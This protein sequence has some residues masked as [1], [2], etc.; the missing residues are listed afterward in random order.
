MADTDALWESLW[1]AH[2]DGQKNCLML[3]QYV[4][5]ETS[6]DSQVKDIIADILAQ[7]STGIV[8]AHNHPSGDAT[9]STSDLRASRY[10]ATIAEAVGCPVFD[11]LIFAGD[12]CISFRKMGLL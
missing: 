8:L 12:E 6:V 1:V 10:L 11:H 5:D 9:P 3:V 7:N 4:G 2:L